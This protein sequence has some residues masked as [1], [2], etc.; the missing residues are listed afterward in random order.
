M[1][2]YNMGQIGPQGQAG[3]GARVPH[4]AL[5]DVHGLEAHARQ[6]LVPLAAG[7]AP[8]ADPT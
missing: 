6:I 8:D 3:G 1:G 7:I 5:L 2:A 4:S